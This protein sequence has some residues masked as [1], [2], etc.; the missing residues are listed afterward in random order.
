ME[1]KLAAVEFRSLEKY[2]GSTPSWITET[3]LVGRLV[4]IVK[5]PPLCSSFEVKTIQRQLRWNWQNGLILGITYC[6]ALPSSTGAHFVRSSAAEILIHV[7]VV[8]RPA[9]LQYKIE[10]SDDFFFFT[11]V[12]SILISMFFIYEL[13]KSL[14]FR[15]LMS[16]IYIYIYMEHL[17]LMFLDHTQRRTTVGRTPLD[18]WSARLRDLCLTTHDTHNRQIS[19]PPVGFEPMISADERPASLCVI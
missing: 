6:K 16:Y 17:F 18:E 2:V 1:K 5:T 14:N 8:F 7:R 10:L 19:M 13:I 3:P 15:L 12:P 11:V 4:K 9:R